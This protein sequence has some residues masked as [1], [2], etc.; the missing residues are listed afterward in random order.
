MLTKYQK[1]ILTRVCRKPKTKKQAK[2]I[3]K[4]KTQD[5]VFEYAISTFFEI[6]FKEGVKYAHKK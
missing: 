6:G 5:Q 3:K 4:C 2:D 1:A